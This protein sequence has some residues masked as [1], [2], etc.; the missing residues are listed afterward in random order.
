MPGQLRHQ[1]FLR[2]LAKTREQSAEWRLFAV[3]LR[4]LHRIDAWAEDD[5]AADPTIEKELFEDV[6]SLGDGAIARVLASG[7]A[8]IAN[9]SPRDEHRASMAGSLLK[10][11]EALRFQC[12]YDLSL[13][14]AQTAME[15]ASQNDRLLWRSHVE[16]A[17][18][19]R[20]LGDFVLSQAQYECCLQIAERLGDAEAVYRGR[21]GL[22]RIA[23]E[24]GNLPLAEE[25]AS[26]LVS[27][28]AQQGDGELESQARQGLAV[29][30][31]LRGKYEDARQELE[32][33]L[34]L[35]SP[36]WRHRVLNDLAFVWA[37]TGDLERARDAFVDL[38][39]TNPERH[40]ALMARVNLIQVFGSLGDAAAVDEQGDLL[41]DEVLPD[42]LAVDFHMTLGTAYV[43]LGRHDA[44]LSRYE[45]ARVLAEQVGT[46]QTIIEADKQIDRLRRIGNHRHDGAP[47]L[48]AADRALASE[49]GPRLSASLE[50]A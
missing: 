10:L 23:R 6:E 30:L 29:T 46:G 20:V 44:A 17:F 31:G 2:R 36:E 3:T 32:R 7:I 39:A 27:W 11:D 48:S 34:I 1:P 26:D 13:D 41:D 19:H 18:A 22:T 37:Q 15:F 43:A 4:V 21:A 40:C 14:V 28:T 5:R 42:A 47:N 50:Q 12:W 9:V 25:L 49:S 35:S 24:R 8:L 38:A 33:A 16:C 45:R